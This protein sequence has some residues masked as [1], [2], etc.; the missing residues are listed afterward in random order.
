MNDNNKNNP[1]AG[2]PDSRRDFLRMASVGA[3]AGSAI[4]ATSAVPAVAR[5]NDGALE[6]G[7]RETEHVKTYYQLA[8]F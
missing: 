6:D 3:V 2:K 4:A 1:A 8:K 7:Y 5:E